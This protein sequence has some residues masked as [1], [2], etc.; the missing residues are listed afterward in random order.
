MVNDG[1]SKKRI[2]EEVELCQ[3]LCANCHRKEHVTE[4]CQAVVNPQ[5]DLE[6]RIDKASKYDARRL[7]RQWVTEYKR[8]SDGCNNCVES[9]PVTLDFHHLE[10]KDMRISSMVSS[11]RS[12]EEI[13]QEIQKCE[14]LCANC[15]RKEHFEPPP[16]VE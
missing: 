5:K 16:E 2:L 10:N 3:V 6:K 12:L 4:S 7:R 11:G 15:H 13:K 14:L 1:Y 9:M 8:A